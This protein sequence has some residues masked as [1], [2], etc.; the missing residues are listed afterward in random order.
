MCWS[1]FVVVV[2]LLLVGG[3]LKES[4]KLERTPKIFLSLK[5]NILHSDLRSLD[6]NAS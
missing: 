6:N 4:E 2:L 1:L 3:K 5:K